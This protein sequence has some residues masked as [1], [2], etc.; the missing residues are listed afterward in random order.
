MQWYLRNIHSSDAAPAQHIRLMQL[1]HAQYVHLGCGAAAT[2]SSD[3]ART[4]CAKV[5]ISSHLVMQHL[6]YNTFIL[7][8]AG[9]SN[10]I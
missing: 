8:A 9:R 7:H 6:R 1:L 10:C 3:A 5:L 2:P 4:V